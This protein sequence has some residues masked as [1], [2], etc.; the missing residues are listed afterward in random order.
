MNLARALLYARTLRHLRPEQ[1]AFLPLRRVQARLALPRTGPGEPVDPARAAPLAAEV[2]GWGP[3]D[4]D[5]RRARADEVRAGVFRFLNHAES[6]PERP[7]WTARRVG[8]LWSY[9]LHYFAYAVDLAWAWRTTGDAAYAHRFSALARGWIA[10]TEG[11]RGDGWEP[12]ALATRAVHW[13]EALLLFGDGLDA[14]TRDVVGRS[15]W[16]QLAVLERRLERHLLANHLQRDLQALAVGGLL[17][18]GADAAR[19]RR[20]GARGLWRELDEQV[21][22]DGGHFERSPMYHAVAL[23]DYLRAGALLR[24]GG[25]PIPAA[26][27]ARLRRMTRAFGVLSRP[28][29]TLHLFNDAAQGEAPGRAEL[30]ALARRVLGEGVPVAEGRLELAETGY[31]GWAQA[32]GGTRLL[33]DC[34]LPGPVYQPGHAHCDLL[35]FE[36]DLA[37]RPVVVDAGV[38]GYDGD[39]F[40][41]YARSTRAHNTLAIGGREQSEVWGTFRVGGRAEP[42][43]P[44][45]RADA[46]GAVFEGGCRPWHDRRT[47]HRRTMEV[48]GGEL[49]VTDRVDG[50]AGAALESYLHLHPDFAVRREGD[51]WMATRPGQTVVVEAWGVDDV[52]LHAGERE[53][54]QGWHLPEFGRAL[55][56]PVLRLR[57][58]A[59]DGRRFGYRI[60]AG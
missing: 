15:L 40:R 31:F 18:G 26:A 37:G 45:L 28:D 46:D 32:G 16:R 52:S 2:A 47:I 6:L 8:H 17:F 3:G 53:P 35:S 20:T 19:W 60:R 44:V 30:D 21:L 5:A 23:D 48:A 42:V 12:Y 55:P 51:A 10:A 57:V 1:L 58:H 59:N 34:G 56:A 4:A 38:S 24:V 33:V 22:G 36:L 9:H 43:E 7:E 49:A 29:G 50:S 11:G 14:E 13:A 27:E 39:P 54:V 41:E 25:E